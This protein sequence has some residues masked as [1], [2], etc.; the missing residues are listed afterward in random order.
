MIASGVTDI[1]AWIVSLFVRLGLP[2]AF[3]AIVY[4]SGMWLDRI[5]PSEV[6]AAVGNWMLAS[7]GSETLSIADVFIGAFDRV[8]AVRNTF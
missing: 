3:A 2:A 8:F 6:R 1:E 5:L 7:P 4:G